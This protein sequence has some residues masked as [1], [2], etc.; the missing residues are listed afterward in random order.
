MV[1]IYDIVRVCLSQTVSFDKINLSD[2]CQPDSYVMLFSLTHGAT[3][4]CKKDKVDSSSA[5]LGQSCWQNNTIRRHFD[6]KLLVDLQKKIRKE[7]AN[8]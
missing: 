2:V 1:M 7:M 8:V 5:R 4:G 6:L 3:W